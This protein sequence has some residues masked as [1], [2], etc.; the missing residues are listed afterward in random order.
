MPFK[1]DGVRQKRVAQL[2]D[3]MARRGLKALL[4]S[5]NENLQFC[6]NIGLSTHY[7]ERPSIAMIPAEG[8]P[9]ALLNHVS[10][11]GILMQIE[12]QISWIQDVRFYTELPRVQDRTYTTDQFTRM[13]Q[14]SLESTGLDCGVIGYDSRTS[15]IAELASLLP[16]VSFVSIDAELRKLRRVKHADE[17]E[18]VRAAGALGDWAM[19]RLKELLSPGRG[20][21]E[22]SAHVTALVLD[23]A[24]R[25]HPGSN[26]QVAKLLT[27]SG[28]ASSSTDGDGAPTGATVE[29]N[30]PI[31]SV[32][33][34]RMNGYSVEVHRTF[35][36]GK[37]NTE[38]RSLFETALSLNEAAIAQVYTKNRLSRIDEAVHEVAYK[39][40]Y[41]KYLVHRAGHGI[42]ISTHEPPEDL[43]FNPR[44]IEENELFSLEP[45]LYVKG[46]GG[47]RIG[48][49]VVA[50]GSPMVLTA[51]P[52][53]LA[54]SIIN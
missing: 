14:E 47:F 28:A 46:L 52:K 38:Q 21:Q 48:D 20:L 53:S 39:K 50:Q 23:E 5:G 8:A 27:L 54:D 18:I 36:C 41:Y 15:H 31:V 9:F 43:P 26:F 4:I 3:L 44:P 45:G 30:V 49:V 1:M 22:V 6:A 2:G 13:V 35:F 42:G 40:G 24:G 17:I 25:R 7:W 29:A 10:E 32:I 19:S 11:N 16:R 34:P 51:S 12:R 33:V 37:P